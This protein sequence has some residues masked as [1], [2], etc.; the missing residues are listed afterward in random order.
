MSPPSPA[1]L[2]Y[3]ATYTPYLGGLVGIKSIPIASTSVVNT[4]VTAPYL[5]VYVLLDNSGSM[6]IAALPSDI[7]TMQELTACSD[8]GAYYCT[9]TKNGS[10]ATWSQ[11]G[12]LVST[13]SNYKY[14]NTSVNDTSQ[15]SYSVYGCTGSGYSYVSDG[16][17]FCSIGPLTAD[18][19]SFPAFPATGSNPGPGCRVVVLPTLPTTQNTYNG[20]PVSAG[21]PCAFACHFD[22]SSAAGTGNDYYAVARSTLGGHHPGHPALRPGQDRP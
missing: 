19:I 21:P 20:Y 13:Q 8:T 7:Q 6:E 17:N 15:Q 3:T 10:C 5:N 9:V 4:P 18:G 16:T 12:S 2:T 1:Q 11:S 22:T 14:F